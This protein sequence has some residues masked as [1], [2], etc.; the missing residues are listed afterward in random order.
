MAK[1]QYIT[2]KGGDRL[3][4]SPFY[5]GI[6]QHERT[7]SRKETYAFLADRMGYKAT[8]I[9]AVFMGLAA[10]AVENAGKGNITQVDGVAS[11]RNTCHGPFEG[12]TG[13]WIKGK[14]FLLVTSVALDPFKSVLSGIVPVNRTEGAKPVINTVYDESALEY[15]QVTLGETFSIAGSDL[16]PDTEKDDEKV[17]LENAKGEAVATA[18]VSYSDLQNVKGVFTAAAVEP[19]EY[20]LAVYTR[21]GMGEEYGVKKATRKVAVDG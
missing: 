14:N 3:A 4:R 16:G 10:Y 17:V 21:S 19:G 8:A 15:G 5:I 20:T 13:P 9:R 18:T 11:I 1:V 6:P 7:M 2:A 12:L